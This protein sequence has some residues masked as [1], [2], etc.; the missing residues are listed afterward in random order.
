MDTIHL[1]SSVVFPPVTLTEPRE[2]LTTGTSST[3]L[4]GILYTYSPG[5]YPVE[6]GP[7]P[8]EA[9][10]PPPGPPPGHLAGVHVTVGPPVPVCFPGEPGCGAVCVDD[11]VPE[12]PCIGVCGCIGLG[13]PGG[14]DCIGPGCGA[15]EDDGS[16]SESKPCASSTT[17]SNCEVACSVTSASGA[18]SYTISCYSTTCYKSE[19]CDATATT[20]TSEI[21]IG[22]PTLPPY[23]SWWTN[24]DELLPTMGAGGMGGAWQFTETYSSETTPFVPDTTA[25]STVKSSPT[26]AKESSKSIAKSNPTSSHGSSQPT[27]SSSPG[28]T[29]RGCLGLMTT[30][31]S[32]E[33]VYAYVFSNPGKPSIPLCPTHALLTFFFFFFTPGKDVC[34]GL[35]LRYRRQHR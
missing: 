27:P 19:G 23:T 35:L 18:S 2:T 29:G 17:V 16:S 34:D 30:A 7:A 22:C 12:V 26:G 31:T 28:D 20:T 9:T 14:G 13:C 1:I 33:A 11:C 25:E 24:S 4:A 5:P 3:T 32:E 6:T 10:S 15:G 21:T 8:G